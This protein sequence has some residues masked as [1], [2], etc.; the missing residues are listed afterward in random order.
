MAPQT[1]HYRATARLL[2]WG[3]AILLIGLIIAGF[4]MVQ[5]GLPQA[6]QNQL[7]AMHKNIGL[8]VL[9]LVLLRLAYRMVN[10][11][12]PLPAS[13]SPVQRRIAAVSHASLYLL[14]IAM[15]VLGYVR[16]RAGGFPVESLDAW[17]VPALIAKSEPL[18]AAA[19]SAHYA[20]ALLLTA[21]VVLHVGAALYHALVLRDGVF[22]RMATGGARR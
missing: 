14:M 3:M 21:L 10:P 4:I 19:K 2:H 17:G 9:V 7:F 20:G 15:P 5:N 22:A 6:L 13:I 11:A 18:A 12:P 8:L 16:V 1:R